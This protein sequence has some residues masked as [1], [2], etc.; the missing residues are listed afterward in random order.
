VSHQTAAE[1]AFGADSRSGRRTIP[2]LWRAAVT[3]EHAGPAYLIERDGRW[4]PVGWDEASRRV[5]DLANGLLAL[6]IRKGDAFGILASTRLE[7]CLFDFALA[8]VGGITAPVYATSSSRD[9][10]HVLG[11]SEAVGL[12]VEDEAKR[13][14][15]DELRGELPRLE[16]VLT[17]ADLDELAARGRAFAAVDPSALDEAIAA[18]AEDDLYTYIYTSG[19]TGPPKACMIRHR[20]FY[21]MAATVDSLGDFL[22]ERDVLLLFLPLA[23]NFGRLMHL[24]GPY[25]GYTTA[26]CPDPSRVAD[27]L[28]VVRPTFFPSVPRLYEKIHA[29]ALVK[30]DEAGGPRRA[31]VEWALRVGR[32]TSAL[33]R[34]GRALPTVLAV[35]HRLANRLVYS[36]IKAR[37]GGRIRIAVSGGAPL[38]P[39]IAEFFHALDVLILEGYGQTECTSAAAVNL[40]GRVRFGT[41]GPALP[42][43]EV[44][45]ADDGELLLRSETVFAGYFKDEAATRSVLGEDGWLRTGDV[46]RIEDGF[47]SITDRKK[48][49]IVTAGGKNVSPQNLESELKNARLVS[50]AMV[51]GDRRPCLAALIT[52][53][54]DEVGRWAVVNGIEGDLAA[55]AARQEV[56]ALVAQAVEEV[57]RERSG[58]EQ[59]KRFA[60][61]GRDFT[62]EAGEVTPTLK[63]KRRVCE[64]HFAD[65]IE[66]L[67]AGEA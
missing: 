26:L 44:Q 51:I 54:A 8:L 60:I 62:Q 63:L 64:E 11:H 7:W 27:A 55:L 38:A 13:A 36:K 43:F 39:E 47:I 32:R 52:L 16:H 2:A 12:L 15:V 59:I 25:T 35:Q 1:P 17:F 57:N 22:T 45:V 34:E 58:F 56:R 53:D 40:P 49:I 18:I 46:A 20:N 9:C 28:V 3:R 30:F 24:L 41:V 14:L 67:Y 48:D 19:T 6:G 10:A 66:R 37:L 61:L 5:D 33:Q 4:E 42:G 21:A 23:H 65:E 31:I 29:A 50:Q